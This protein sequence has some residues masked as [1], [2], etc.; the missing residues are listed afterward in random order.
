MLLV[1][2]L[3]AL[4]G[5]GCGGG[6]MR[7]GGVVSIGSI[8]LTLG[9]ARVVTPQDG[10]PVAV[11]ATIVRSGGDLNPVTLSAS[12][13]PAGVTATFNQPETD[14]VGSVT[15]SSQASAAAGTY[16]ATV[17]ATDG[18][19]ISTAPLTVVVAVVA[20]VSNSTDT[21]LGVGGKL[22]EAMSTSFQPATWDDTFFA[23][24]SDVTPLTEL[25]P[26]H[27]RVQVL[28]PPYASSSSSP[29]PGDWNFTVLDSV[30]Q[31]VLSAADHSPE[32]QI[33]EA[34]NILGM[35][36]ASGQMIVNSTNLMAFANYAANLVRYYNTGG[37]DWAGRHFR[38]PSD[39]P[40]HWWGI[41]N[42]YN[43]NGLTPS[44]YIQL[45]NT[46]VPAMLAVDPTIQFSA[47]ELYDFDYQEGD[48]RNNLPAFVAP[49]SA[50]GVNA[51][52]GV[53]S[54]HFYST[55]DQTDTD[56]TVF[57]TVPGFVADVQY[58]YRAL[59]S[60]P[61]LST[62]PVWVTENNVNSDYPDANGYSSCN[63]GQV[64]VT[65][66]RG[67]S[68]FFAAWRPYVFS[69]LGKAGNQALYHWDYDADQQ[70]GEVS[71]TSGAKYLSYWVDYWLG[72]MLPAAPPPDI[73]QLTATDTTS[74]ETL[75]TR[76]ADGSVVVMVVNRAVHSPN[77]DN[78][79][80]NPRTVVVDVSAFGNFSS[81]NE[82]ALDAA[83]DPVNGPGQP[84]AT[85]AAVRMTVTLGGYGVTFLHLKP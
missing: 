78:G 73:L 20:V 66:P 85:T 21:A 59:Q 43:I 54:T 34:P 23:E 27:I 5:P 41:F 80:G 8:A 28:E 7:R 51:P 31:P 14:T 12:G 22:A 35:L 82:L 77:D 18:S 81:A 15:F 61:D 30:L 69:E 37:F 1:A 50:G 26:H 42:E 47:L 45:Y 74:V 24:Y 33:A 38:S 83:T 40:I 49:A 17:S 62:V 63:P 10:T 32:L 11:T 84:V 2:I 79:A 48:P 52:V 25:G 56:A 70:Y 16:A 67:T 71:F 57:A 60:R 53:A 36:N 44:E 65:D 55:C 13:L 68:A 76:N 46:T 4:L 29:S 58:F 39:Y 6:S 19:V 64:F 72:Q 9:S 75:A 3:P